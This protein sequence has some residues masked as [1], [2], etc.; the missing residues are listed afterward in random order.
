[1]SAEAWEELQADY[2]RAERPSAKACMT[3][4]AKRAEAPAGR[5]LR[6]HAG[7][8]PRAPAA[9]DEG[10]QARRAAGAKDLFPAQQRDKSARSPRSRSINGDGYKHNLWVKLPDGAIDRPKTW[11]WQDV[12]SSKILAWRIDKTEHTKQ[13]R[14]SFG[15]A[16]R[17]ATAS[18]ARCCSTTRSPRRT[19]R[20]RAASR[21]ASAS[22]CARTSPT[23]SSSCSASRCTGRRRARPG[24]ADRARLRHRRRRRVHRQGARARRRLDGRSTARQARVRRPHKPVAARRARAR[25]RARGRGAGTP[26]RG[27]AAR[28]TTAARSTRCSPSP[29]RRSRWCAVRGAGAAAGS[30]RPSPCAPTRATVRSRST[31]AREG[32]AA[33]QSLLGCV[34]LRLCRPHARREVRPAPAAPGRARLHARWQVDLLRR[35]RSRRR[36]QRPGRRARA[37]PRQEHLRARA[38]RRWRGDRAHGGSSITASPRRR[39]GMG[40]VAAGTIPAPKVIRAMFNEPLERPRCRA[41][42]LAIAERRGRTLEAELAELSGRGARRTS[43]PC[44]TG[45]PRLLEAPRRAPP[46]AKRSPSRSGRTGRTGSSRTT[47]AS[48]CEDDAEL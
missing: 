10:A 46:R 16:L 32:R 5:C 17:G 47:S 20:C 29:M 4:L 13:I 25:D 28:C 45:P 18:R 3:R 7:A 48:P 41:A 24:E 38:S 23:A 27:G 43:S 35:V 21:T 39:S 26:C 2:L 8:A 22:R 30:S 12:Y 34:A 33:R 44:A 37:K 31:P 1:M 36:L 14:L 40:G 11:F 42:S 15:D 19:R 9:R 6:A